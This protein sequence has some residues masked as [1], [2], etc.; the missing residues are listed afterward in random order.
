MTRLLTVATAAGLDLLL[1]AILASIAV[2]ESSIAVPFI[3]AAALVFVGI[4]FAIFA[5]AWRTKG[6][7]LRHPGGNPR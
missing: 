1:C 2:P 3:A 5:S 4:V 6:W 7:S